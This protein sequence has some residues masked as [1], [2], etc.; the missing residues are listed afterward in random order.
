MSKNAKARARFHIQV[1]RVSGVRIMGGS[2]KFLEN[3]AL[4]HGAWG[5]IPRIP[6]RTR[7]KLGALWYDMQMQVTSKV[8]RCHCTA[9]TALCHIVPGL[10]KPF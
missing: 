3:R 9:Y 5:G 6:K 10:S 1:P 8:A 7:N 4:E 2:V